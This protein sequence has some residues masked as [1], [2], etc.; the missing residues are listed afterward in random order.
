MPIFLQSEAY[1]PWLA[2]YAYGIVLL[3]IAFF[4]FRVFENWFAS[5]FDRPLF[6]HYFVYR[7]L[8]PSQLKILQN[9]F[10]FYRMLS[11]KNK[12]QFVHRMAQFLS[13]KKIIGRE[14]VIITEKMKV[15][16][17]AIACMLSFGRR[18]YTYNLVDFIL[19]YP[20][21]FYSAIN[22]AYHKGEFNPREKVIVLS[23]KDFEK[24]YKI[25][26]DNLN[27]G[28]HEFT[29]A[30]QLEAKQ[31]RDLDSARFS[32]HF[33]AILKQ[34]MR[35]DV[36]D[37]LDK[38]RYFREYAFTN[39]YEFMAVLTEYFFESPEDFKR[40]FPKIYEHTKKLLNFNF[41]DY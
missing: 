17:A 41:A 11:E 19:I 18:N 38:T 31:A 36:K 3:G 28:I 32:K 12:K 9:E 13:E 7:K 27:I 34:L 22:D 2:P 8:P 21:E 5:N 30:M 20:E 25:E 23:W 39:Q 10:V 37:Q 35:Q 1:A 24:G 33:Q 26:N 16:V 6:R 4:L 29:H 14:E 15:L 40:I